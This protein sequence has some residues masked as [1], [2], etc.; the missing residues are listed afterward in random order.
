MHPPEELPRIEYDE[1]GVMKDPYAPIPY[2][3]AWEQYGA[4]PLP[5][6]EVFGPVTREDTTPHDGEQGMEKAH[7]KLV[8]E[9]KRRPH[10]WCFLWQAH[11]GST[12]RC[13][14]VLYRFYDDED[15]MRARDTLEAAYKRLGFMVTRT[16]RQPVDRELFRKAERIR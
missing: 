7:W 9:E 11:V 14:R 15:G 13:V 16:G 8:F 5:G 2:D 10:G 12:A 6:I 4:L 1:E 3:P